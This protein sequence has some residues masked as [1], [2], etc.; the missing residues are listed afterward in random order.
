MRISFPLFNHG[1]ERKFIYPGTLA[2]LSLLI[3][4]SFLNGCTAP[5]TKSNDQAIKQANQREDSPTKI[6]ATST[7]E[8]FV[9]IASPTAVK[10]TPKVVKPTIWIS[11]DL[12]AGF[13][14]SLNIPLTWEQVND[15]NEANLWL[16]FSAKEPDSTSGKSEKTFQSTWVYVVTAPFPTVQDEV[17]LADI[18]KAWTGDLSASPGGK[19]LLMTPD[20]KAV[21]DSTWG[22]SHLWGPASSKGVRIVNPDE[23]LNYAWEDQSGWAVVPFESIEP[24]WKVLKL[25]GASPL[26]RFFDE[27]SYPLAFPISLA[28]Q[29][30]SLASIPETFL[31]PTNRDPAK[32]TILVMTGVTALSRHIAEAMETEGVNYP[33]RDIG[34]WLSDADLTH[35]S[36]EVSFYQDCPKA[37]PERADMRFC[38]NPKYIGLLE[39]AGTDIVELT[40]NH[41]LDWGFQPYF[42]TLKMYSQRGWKTYGGGENL[43]VARKALLV[44]HNGNK[45]AFLGCSP[46]G[47]DAVWATPDEPGSAPCNFTRLEEQVRNLKEQGYLPIVTLQAF[48]TDVYLP[49]PAQGAPDFRKIARARSSHC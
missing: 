11:P 26:D 2:I 28:G 18:R 43:E 8:T 45:L 47:P 32:L 31:L 20:T 30:R 17:S 37:G 21:L 19:P 9:D 10:E 7:N 5:E 15:H 44:E 34:T 12:P 46:A 14:D 38:S 36:N 48:E 1:F 39:T 42:D 24:H 3:L 22:T 29:T 23:L 41:N 27:S 4:A 16:E 49:P 40:G 33:A 6:A 13:R 35:I 25:N